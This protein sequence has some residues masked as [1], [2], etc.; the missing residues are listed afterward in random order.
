MV[1]SESRESWVC[2]IG[3]LLALLYLQ[4]GKK[5]RYVLSLLYILGGIFL[6]IFINQIF[7]IMG[8]DPTFTGRTFIWQEC[9]KAITSSPIVGYGYKAFWATANGPADRI[10]V[11]LGY[12][13]PHAH[14][15]ILELGLDLGFVGIAIY[16]VSLAQTLWRFHYLPK[17][18]AKTFFA[19]FFVYLGIMNFADSAIMTPNTVYWAFYIMISCYGCIFKKMSEEEKAA[20]DA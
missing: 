10:S 5:S 17:G 18:I 14:N 4:L 19:V 16:L 3:L 15:G 7:G 12:N 6:G 11:N 2:L 8:R 9:W 1:L 13:V 20:Q